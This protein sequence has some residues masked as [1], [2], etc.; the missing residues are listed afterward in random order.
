[1]NKKILL[2]LVFCL[3]LAAFYRYI[4]Q[5]YDK[6]NNTIYTNG[7]IITLESFSPDAEAMFVKNGIIEAIGT[8]EDVAK[9]EERGVAVIDL[10]GAIVLPGFID[11]HTHAALSALMS[12]MVDLSGF[13]H[14]SNESFDGAELA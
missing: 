10:K 14:D 13:T 8:N 11:P 9:F 2:L 7:N 5:D 6:N 1:M 3:V 4:N 12:G